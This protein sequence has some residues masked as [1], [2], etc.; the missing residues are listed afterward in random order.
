MHF[1]GE[2]RGGAHGTCHNG[3]TATFSALRFLFRTTGKREEGLKTSIRLIWPIVGALGVASCAAHRPEV[4]PAVPAPPV[5]RATISDTF[6][7]PVT[8]PPVVQISLDEV[9]RAVV[10]ITGDTAP[11][12]VV[13]VAEPA[14]DVTSD[15]EI[16]A[17]ASHERVT[18]FVDIFTGRARD[19]FSE[20]LTRGTRYEPMIRSKLR[21]ASMPEDLYYLALIESGF[22]PDAYSSAA[23]VGVWQFMTATAKGEGL[24]VD[25]WVDERRDPSLATTAA[26]KHLSWLRGQFGSLFLA[27]AAYNGGSGLVSRGLTRHADAVGQVD[28]E[29]MFF[30]LAETNYLRVET[31]DYVPK[32]IAAALVAK[33]ARK[34]DIMHDTLPPLMYDSVRVAPA[35]PL[36]AIAAAADASIESIVELNNH[37][38]RGVTHPKEEMWVRVP[39]GSTG[40]FSSA[41]A[42]LP[43]ADK[44]PYTKTTSKAG[45]TF[46]AV[47]KRLRVTTKQLAWYN[48]RDGASR[49]VLPAGTTILVPSA[50]LLAAAKDV[51]DPAVEIYGG[52]GG[53]YVVRRGDTLSGIAKKFRVTVAAIKRLNKLSGDAIRV[54]QT[55]RVR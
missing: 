16:L 31:R 32:L 38:L 46:A 7:P 18:H 30:A 51:P 45:E 33:S 47:A 6:T 5:E 27:A 11:V 50:G 19:Q 42:A 25:W 21:A 12:P 28:G 55:L 2:E 9:N 54:G 53:R 20:W 17:F 22:S 48:P 15:L 37:I 13:T 14:M 29:E 34:Y 43:A 10:A 36:S 44:V 1:G 23:A 49:K 35:T 52:S 39:A 24:K 41:F 40:G 26:V 8:A 3:T 4:G